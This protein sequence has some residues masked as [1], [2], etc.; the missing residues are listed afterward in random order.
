MASVLAGDIAGWVRTGSAQRE[1]VPVPSRLAAQAH[2]KFS[3]PADEPAAP[4]QGAER[5]T[6][7]V[8]S[9]TGPAADAAQAG[10]TGSG[11]NV[12]DPVQQAPSTESSDRS[13]ARTPQ[14]LRA[15]PA[16]PTPVAGQA[17]AGAAEPEVTASES[18]DETA[19][20]VEATASEDI[21]KSESTDAILDASMPVS[22]P[23]GIAIAN[24]PPAIGASP[25]PSIAPDA[26]AEHQAEGIARTDQAH[27]ATRSSEIDT[28]AGERSATSRTGTRTFEATFAASQA[29]AAPSAQAASSTDGQGAVALNQPLGSTGASEAK[30]AAPAVP[31]AQTIPPVPLG[32]VPMTIGLRALGATSRFEIRLDPVELGRIE[33]SL[34]I[35]RKRGAVS[36]SLVVERPETLAL[37]QRDASSL[38]QALSQAGLDAS[39]DIALSLRSGEQGGQNDRDADPRRQ[40]NRPE[41]GEGLDTSAGI[42]AVPLRALRAIGGVDIRI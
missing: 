38:Q 10:T 32:A 9:S 36:A 8:S 14:R 25:T 7:A 24:T 4:S 18:A 37:L 29:E 5:G 13:T 16:N 34:D 23:V 35:D 42:N 6:I 1:A 41:A 19:D 2:E 20:A 33:V 28:E 26:D 21:P 31:T 40:G 15:L 22:S 17:G 12:A 11:S 39:Q 27:T 30:P 3:L